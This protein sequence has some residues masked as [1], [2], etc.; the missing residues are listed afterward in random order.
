MDSSLTQTP[1]LCSFK[2]E[3]KVCHNTKPVQTSLKANSRRN[4]LV[5]TV[6]TSTPI[7]LRDTGWRA[8]P[9]E[10]S[11]KNSAL[12]RLAYAAMLD[13]SPSDWHSLIPGR[14]EGC[15]NWMKVR[16]FWHVP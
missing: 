12:R 9:L 3:V 6:V 4:L 8:M 7:P 15:R 13:S 5:P 11:T 10:R 16:M 14:R 1:R 2:S